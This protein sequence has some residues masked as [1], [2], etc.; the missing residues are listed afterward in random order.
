MTTAQFEALSAPLQ[1]EE[2]RAYFV[3]GYRLTPD[4]G[5]GEGLAGLA[6]T[7]G[8]GLLQRTLGDVLTRLRPDT[9]LGNGA[10]SP[11]WEEVDRQ[12]ARKGLHQDLMPTVDRILHGVAPEAGGEGREPA[13]GGDAPL[14]LAEGNIRG[15]LLL[16]PLGPRFG[17]RRRSRIPGQ[18]SPVRQR[19]ARCALCARASIPSP[20]LPRRARHM[21]KRRPRS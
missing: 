16:L 17:P 11:V 6:R 20:V 1:A 18:R 4:A 2:H 10:G 15:A 19:P 13:Y 7:Y 21:T 3:F 5:A 14:A 8:C 9:P 12:S